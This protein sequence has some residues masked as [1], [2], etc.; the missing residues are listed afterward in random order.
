M[1]DKQLRAII[2]KETGGKGYHP[3][4]YYRGL[5]ASEVKKRI[6]HKK[7]Q[8]WITDVGKTTKTSQYTTAFRKKYP[9]AR[10]LVAK[11]KATGVPIGIIKAVYDR[12]L[13]A[14]LSG[15][16]PGASQT[17]WGY[18][19]VHSFLMK[20]CTYYTTDKDLVRKA[21]EKMKGTKELARW[22]RLPKICK[23]KR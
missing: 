7:G 13:G 21:S 15:H 6:A 3:L 8:P 23:L 10:S 16:R 4:K 2:K 18:A 22:K 9:D 1:E 11:S 12:G 19:R 5:T 20:G 14:W 17:A